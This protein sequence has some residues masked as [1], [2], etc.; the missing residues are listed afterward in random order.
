MARILLRMTSLRA[1]AVAPDGVRGHKESNRLHVLCR[2]VSGWDSIFISNRWTGG[3]FPFP[4][5]A[6]RLYPHITTCCLPTQHT[7]LNVLCV[8]TGLCYVWFLSL[9]FTSSVV[10]SSGCY[11][12]WHFNPNFSFP[13]PN[14]KI[15]RWIVFGQIPDWWHV[16]R[17]SGKWM[18]MVLG[19]AADMGEGGTTGSRWLMILLLRWGDPQSDTQVGIKNPL[20]FVSFVSRKSGLSWFLSI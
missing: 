8:F 15:F 11:N 17:G 12:H 7:G 19:G 14:W 4:W 2:N 9:H 18:G 20:Q 10:K 3:W 1:E 16:E 5:W 6:S 13:P